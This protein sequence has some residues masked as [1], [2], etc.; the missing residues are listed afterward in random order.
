LFRDVT[1]YHR[2]EDDLKTSHQELETANEEL[3]STNEELETT[4]EELLSTV[5]ELETTNEELQST[6]E[7]LETMNEEM[8]S[9]NEDLQTANEQLKQSGDEL[10]RANAFLENILS[11]FH[12]GLIVVDDDLRVQAW[13]TRSEDLWGLRSAEVQGKHLMTS[14]SVFRWSG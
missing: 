12:D 6:N 3:Q 14:T 1:R 8:Q 2:L 10:N 4:N 9:T 13:N 7:E 11:N 5:E